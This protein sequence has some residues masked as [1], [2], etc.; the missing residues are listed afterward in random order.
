M[1]A[2]IQSLNKLIP[3]RTERELTDNFCVAESSLRASENQVGFAP[4]LLQIVASDSFALNTRLAAALYFKNLL[5]RNWTVGPPPLRSSI[6]GGIIKIF[7]AQ[8]EEGHYKMAESEV[9]AVKRDLVGL[10]ITV[11][12]ALQVQLGEAISIIAESDFWQRWDTLIDVWSLAH[13]ALLGFKT[14][15]DT[16][17][18]SCV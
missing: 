5:G 13:S 18:G 6:Y 15:G 10:M 4:L 7:C 3:P 1:S 2:A 14:Y 11:P 8:D 17:L 9:V 16:E 12:P